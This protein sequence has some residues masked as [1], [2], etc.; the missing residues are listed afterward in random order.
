[1]SVPI[2]HIAISQRPVF[3]VNS[4]LALSSAT[5]SKPCDPEKAILIPK[6]RMQFAEF[7]NVGSLARLRIFISSTCVGLRY[8]LKQPNLRGFSWH[9]DYTSFVSLAI[10]SSS[11][12]SS[13]HGFAY[14]SQRLTPLTGTT[15]ARPGFTSCVTPS[16][17]SEVREY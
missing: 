14:D 7:L 4:R 17:L 6:L 8:G 10:N 11:A 13:S 9:L 5:F 12:L 16:K 15:V 3:L 1:M 2:R